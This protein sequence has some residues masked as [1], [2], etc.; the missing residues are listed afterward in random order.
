MC[1]LCTKARTRLK[2]RRM[3][4]PAVPSVRAC[5]LRRGARLVTG[6]AFHETTCLRAWG[7]LRADAD[8][9]GCHGAGD[10]VTVTRSNTNSTDT[11][12]SANEGGCARGGGRASRSARDPERGA[13]SLGH[14]PDGWHVLSRPDHDRG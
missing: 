2:D 12:G 7:F 10:A 4:K 5:E 13:L 6:R 11:I 14:Q 9:L 8:F 1:A 3:G